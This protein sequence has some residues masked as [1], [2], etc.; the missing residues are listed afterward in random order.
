MGR[1]KSRKIVRRPRKTLP[2]VFQCP[3]CGE[4]SVTVEMKKS[5][6]IAIVGCGVCGRK[7]KIQINKLSEPIDVY[8]AF[9]DLCS[10]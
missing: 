2:N 10:Q 1:R 5:E 6:S 4:T 7:E 9:V 8:S 3:I